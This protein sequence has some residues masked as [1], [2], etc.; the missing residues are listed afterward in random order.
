MPRCPRDTK[1]NYTMKFCRE[2]AKKDIRPWCK[3]CKY[4]QP[5]GKKK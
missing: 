1:L 4:V 5:K 3:H 2:M